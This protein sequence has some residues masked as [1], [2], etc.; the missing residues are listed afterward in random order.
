MNTARAV[1][2]EG[3]LFVIGAVA[4]LTCWIIVPI[5][6]LS[7]AVMGDLATPATWLLFI[8]GAVVPAIV[9]SGLFYRAVRSSGTSAA[10]RAAPVVALAAALGSLAVL[11]Q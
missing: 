5:E 7:I 8:L 6:L 11:N 2:A 9:A 10:M 3:I 1:A 4:T